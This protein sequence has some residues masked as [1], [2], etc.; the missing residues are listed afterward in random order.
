MIFPT[1]VHLK[2]IKRILI[3]SIHPWGQHREK[4]LNRLKDLNDQIEIYTYIYIFQEA[5][6]EQSLSF[7]VHSQSPDVLFVKRG[8]PSPRSPRYTILIKIPFLRALFFWALLWTLVKKL[9]KPLEARASPETT[10]VKYAVI[11]NFNEPGGKLAGRGS[12]WA[13]SKGDKVARS[14]KELPNKLWRA[15]TA[16]FHRS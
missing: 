16:I 11:D 5:R 4:G 2:I 6:K 10:S 8:S 3:I 7:Q 14:S 12:R 9:G 15:T 1:I 13:R